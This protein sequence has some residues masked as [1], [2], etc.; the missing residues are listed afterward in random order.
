[1]KILMD[2]NVLVDNLLKRYPFYKQSDQIIDMCI[3]GDLEIFIAA[4]SVTNAF[5]IMRKE[6]SESRRREMLLEMCNIFEIAD[7]DREKIISCLKKD[8][9]K[10][11]EDCLQAECAAACGADYIV[12]RNVKD[13]SESTVKAVSPEDFLKLC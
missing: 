4:H 8:N 6:Y 3:N 1:M 10:D 13:F 9:F 11:F 5:Y 2:T 12:T 7:I